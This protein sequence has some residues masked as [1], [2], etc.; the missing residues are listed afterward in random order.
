MTR[1]QLLLA[2]GV[3]TVAETVVITAVVASTGAPPAAVATVA[4]VC[5]AAPMVCLLIGLP[6]ALRLFGWTGLARRY[7]ATDP[8]VFGGPDARVISLAI[9]SKLLRLNNVVQAVADERGVHL[10]PALGGFAADAMTLGWSDMDPVGEP[11]R[12][13]AAVRVQEVRVGGTRLW[14]PADL[15]GAGLGRRSADEPPAPAVG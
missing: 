2:I 12:D 7:P 8:A 9:R 1:D 13:L 5:L 10:R 14:L 6:L 4:I 15:I 11:S 3:L